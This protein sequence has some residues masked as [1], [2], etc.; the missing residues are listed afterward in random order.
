MAAEEIRVAREIV[1]DQPWNQCFGCSPHNE[2]GLRIVFVENDDKTVESRVF[3]PEHMVGPPGTVHGGIQA[4]VLDE[5]LGMAARLGSDAGTAWAVTAEL[6][7]RYRRPVPIGVDLVVRGKL[8]RTDGKNL[9]VTG[10]IVGPNQEVLTE[11]EARFK[12][13]SDAPTPTLLGS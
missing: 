8:L 7:L 3:I 12:A 2:R 9:F 10:E 6:Q 5:V 1:N 11:A 13:I 4:A